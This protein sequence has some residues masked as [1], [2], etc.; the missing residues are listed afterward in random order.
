MAMRSRVQ[1]LAEDVWDTPDDGNRYEVIDGELYMTPPPSLAH[2]HVVSRLLMILGGYV[3]EHRLGQVYTA[4]LGVVLEHASGV[5]PDLVYISPRR[6][7]IMSDRGL[8]GAPDLAVE[9]LS[10]STASRDRGIK[11]RRYAASGIEHYWIVDPQV[12]TL[13]AYRLGPSGYQAIV[14]LGQDEVFE[15]ELFPG[16][17]IKLTDLWR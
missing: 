11:M 10:A 16:L 3:H 4:P 12:R 5:Q 15:S 13:E 9:V 8:E 7:E 17:S 2:Q 14:S 1:L 6:T